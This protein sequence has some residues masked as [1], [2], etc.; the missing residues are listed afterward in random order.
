MRVQVNDIRL[1]FDVEGAALRPRG[2]EMVEMPTLLL[3][4]GGPGFDHSHYKPLHGEL[5]EIA[6]VVYLDH[7]GQGRSDRGDRARWRLDQWAD[8]VAAFCAALEIRKPII[9]GSSFGG[10][11]AY[12][13]AARHPELAGKMIIMGSAA[14]ASVPR[15]VRRFEDY[16]GGRAG[17]TAQ[18]F[19]DAPSRET[20]QAYTEHCFPLYARE[21]FDPAL[22]ARSI[23]N[24]ELLFGFFDPAGEGTRFDY[25]SGLAGFSAPTLIVHGERDPI[26]PR[27]L[28]EETYAAFS[29]GVA[30][31]HMLPGCSHNIV[32]DERVAAFKLLRDFIQ[33]P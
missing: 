33:A 5:A 12:A 16:G 8:D 14:H 31:L 19:F 24:E 15:T 4:H 22:A 9:L 23:I 10:F 1:Y 32:D 17:A 25:R 2:H 3:L 30:R 27:E 26:V 21:G 7:R 11:V 29:P 6:Q 20:L 28:A 18:R 13:I